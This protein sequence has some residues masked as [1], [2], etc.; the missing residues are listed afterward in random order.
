MELLSGLEIS[1]IIKS[2][3]GDAVSSDFIRTLAIFTAAAFVHGRQVRKEIKTQISALI[4]VLEADL[5]GQKKMTAGLHDRVE[6][7]EGHVIGTITKS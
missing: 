2:I 3:F 5:Q 1:E 7:L 4:I 6:R